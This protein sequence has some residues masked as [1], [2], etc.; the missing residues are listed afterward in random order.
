MKKLSIFFLLLISINVFSQNTTPPLQ[1]G[2]TKFINKPMLTRGPYLQ[3]ATDTSMVIRWRTDLLARSRVRYGASPNNLDKII[4]DIT[5]KTEHEIKLTGLLPSTKYYYSIGTLKDTLQYGEDNYFSTLPVPGSIGIYRIGVFG[6]CGSLTVNQA[7]VR[8]QFIKYLDRN[9]LNAWILLGDNAYND[10][11]DMEYQAKFFAP[12][13]QTLLKKYPVFPSPGNHDYHDA[14]FT[15]GFAQTTHATPYYQV[16][17]MPVNGEAGGVASKNPAFY[18]FD[19][20]NIHFISLD[21]Y[22]MEENKYFLYDTT[23]PQ[24]KWLKKDLK[25]NKNKGWVI[26]YWHH[27][28]Y[29]K[30]THDSDTDDTEAG[31]RENL[32]RVLDQYEV[33]LILC[34]HSH[35]YERSKF[36]KGHYGNSK[37]FDASKY[38]LS[39][40]SGFYNGSNNSAPYIKQPGNNNGAVYVVSGTSSYVS[41]AAYEWPHPA[42]Y[43]SN[44]TDAGAAILEIQETRLDFKWICADGVIRD[45]FT[46][47]KNVNKQNKMK[48]K[49][50]QSITLKASFISDGYQWSNKET[51]RSIN[52]IP[53]PG[54]STYI[55]KDKFNVLKDTFEITVTK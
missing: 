14:D 52:I 33:D 40:S 55:V 7:R 1:K 47:M 30:G 41:K 19:I 22:G 50:G 5:L 9:D 6:D 17:S 4:D 42:M 53:P 12:Y 16:F 54:T 49:R 20:G 18:S 29:S 32:L 24:V 37:T 25:A 23:G 34:G 15:A 8:D 2:E 51:G 46:M 43:Y 28:P 10:G 38:Q 39:S 3:V 35:V 26:V 21:S 48:V 13:K 27:P 11:N 44:D 31:V 45:Q 36:I